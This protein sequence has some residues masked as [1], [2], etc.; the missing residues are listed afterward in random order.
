M[1]PRYQ[2]QLAHLLSTSLVN[3]LYSCDPPQLRLTKP[4]LPLSLCLSLPFDFSTELFIV[5][6]LVSVIGVGTLRTLVS[7]GRFRWQA[8]ARCLF[9]FLVSPAPFRLPL[10]H[11]RY[12]LPSAV[13]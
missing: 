4:S 13:E 8:L 3:V 1:T 2:P 6:F 10:A 7:I 11:Q 12:V 9:G 5:R